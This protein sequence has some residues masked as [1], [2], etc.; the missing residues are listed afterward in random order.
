MVATI[1]LGKLQDAKTDLHSMTNDSII[2]QSD[3]KTDHD[4][5]AGGLCLAIHARQLK[6]QVST[7][8][9]S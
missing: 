5:K 6:C 4:P 1:S 7:F 3:T 8:F 2:L 9:G